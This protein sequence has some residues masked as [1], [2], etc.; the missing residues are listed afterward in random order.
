MFSTESVVDVTKYAISQLVAKGYSGLADTY[1]NLTALDD[2]IIADLGEQ[3]TLT[4]DDF[5]VNSPADIMFKALLSQLGSPGELL[6]AVT[7]PITN[8]G[9]Q[10]HDVVHIAQ[11]VAE[12]QTPVDVTHANLPVRRHR[13][14]S[15]PP[16]R[17]RRRMLQQGHRRHQDRDHHRCHG[18]VKTYRR[19]RPPNAT[20]TC[21][22]VKP[23]SATAQPYIAGAR[24]SN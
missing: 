14:S 19:S 22:A 18:R 16:I 4:G 23:N 3:L 6:A 9:S 15:I 7:T 21:G 17:S 12:Q 13:P 5:S 11:A 2:H 24:A 1:A 10:L 8:C 20:S